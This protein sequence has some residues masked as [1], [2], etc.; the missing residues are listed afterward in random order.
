MTGISV[1]GVRENLK[2]ESLD[3]RLK[4]EGYFSGFEPQI[5]QTTMPVRAHTRHS[6]SE[7][8][9]EQM[10]LMYLGEAHLTLCRPS[11]SRGLPDLGSTDG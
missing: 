4:N 7:I 5:P 8:T 6:M 2:S 10:R 9:T 1:P 11:A 3:G